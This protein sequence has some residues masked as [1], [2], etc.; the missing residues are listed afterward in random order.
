VS[1]PADIKT[2]YKFSSYSA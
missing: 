2:E 1:L